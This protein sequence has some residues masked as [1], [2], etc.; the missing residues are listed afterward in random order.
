MDIG[1]QGFPFLINGD[2]CLDKD[3][4]G[5]GVG[6]FCLGADC[7]D[8]DTT[9]HAMV[10]YYRDA[11]GDGYGNAD[12]A[13]EVCSLT[14]PAGFVVNSTDVDD[15]DPF[16]TDIS[17]TCAVK[18]IPRIIGWLVGDRERSRL[19]LVI[20]ARGTEFGDNPAIRWESDAITVQNMRVFFKRFM[21]MSAKFDG[22]PLD[23]QYYRVLIG[24]C[25]GKI[26]WAR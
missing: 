18:I 7:N 23:K 3:G 16:Y 21:F 6:G 12:N 22:E 17:P 19:L 14:P 1:P 4:D 11:D 20:G 9:I 5:Y 10:N 2:S 24:D 8:N 15:N 26:K 25:E 13:S